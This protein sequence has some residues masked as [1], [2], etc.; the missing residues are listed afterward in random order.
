[1]LDLNTTLRLDRPELRAAFALGS[2]VIAL[3][4]D[5]TPWEVVEGDAPV[6]TIPPTYTPVVVAQTTPGPVDAT[7]TP[8]PVGTLPPNATRQPAGTSVAPRL[9]QPN[10]SAGSLLGAAAVPAIIVTA[11]S[12]AVVAALA[13]ARRKA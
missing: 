6:V 13:W 7:A 8:A 9:I 2:R 10:A 1:M 11:V 3:T 12:L 4:S 5:G